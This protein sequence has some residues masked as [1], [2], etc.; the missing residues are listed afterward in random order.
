M[1]PT[2]RETAAPAVPYNPE[3]LEAMAC[4]ISARPSDAPRF[5]DVAGAVRAV[6]REVG[7]LVVDYDPTA[8]DTLAAVVE[9]ERRC[10]ADLGWHLE[11]SAHAAPDSAGG[12]VR[13]R[14]EASPAQLDVLATLFD[15]PAGA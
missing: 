4:D 9:A 14:V 8:A 6:R 10:C 7:A 3:L 12:A 1:E 13:L 15:R 2:E 5:E 11:R